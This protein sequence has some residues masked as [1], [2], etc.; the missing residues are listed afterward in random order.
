[1]NNLDRLLSAVE[2]IVFNLECFKTD[3]LSGR[4]RIDKNPNAVLLAKMRM[5]KMTPEQRS[6][7]ARKAGKARMKSLNPT[8]RRELAA[9]AGSAKGKRKK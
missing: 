5:K 4:I 2:T 8:E 7:V 3:L 1:M 6:S 9:R